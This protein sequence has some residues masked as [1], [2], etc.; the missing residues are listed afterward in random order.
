MNRLPVQVHARRDPDLSR[1][2]WLVKWSLLIPHYVVLAGL[3]IA[4]VVTTLV[5]YVAVA[6]TGR[7][8]QAI[9]A[10]NVGVLR[11]GWRVSCYGYQALDTDG[12]APAPAPA[13]AP[14]LLRAG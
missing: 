7:Y 11:W 13:P 9:F 3:W 12:P 6:F 14:E 8:P 2:L 1:W 10:F 5:A 4:F